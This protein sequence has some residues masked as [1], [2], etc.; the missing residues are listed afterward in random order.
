MSSN[1]K[2]SQVFLKK[3]VVVNQPAK[4]PGMSKKDVKSDSRMRPSISEAADVKG[5]LGK[6]MLG[7][8]T[9]VRSKHAHMVSRAPY[10]RGDRVAF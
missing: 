6:R 4:A 2:S 10:S 5:G 8:P 9:V 7:L 3:K 1:K